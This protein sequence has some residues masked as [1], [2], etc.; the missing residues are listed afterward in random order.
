MTLCDPRCPR[1]VR[2]APAPRPR[3]VRAAPA[4]CPRC[5]CAVSALRPRRVRAVSA[6]CL[7]RVRAA[8]A[9]C[10][11]CARAVSALCLRC[12]RTVAAALS[13][14]TKQKTS[15]KHYVPTKKEDEKTEDEY[16][17]SNARSERAGLDTMHRLR[18]EVEPAECGGDADRDSREK[19]RDQHAARVRTEILATRLAERRRAL[20][21]ERH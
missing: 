19:E 5:V 11:R 3:R 9:P 10:P 2:A 17:E 6:L 15:V 18:R 8:P 14:S 16:T 21:A 1:R 20:L 13:Q 12:V 7:R 4:P